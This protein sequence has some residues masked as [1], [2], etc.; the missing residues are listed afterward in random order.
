MCHNQL[1]LFCCCFCPCTLVVVVVDFR[2]L[3]LTFGQNRVIAKILL[4]LCLCGGWSSYTSLCNSCYCYCKKNGCYSI[5]VFSARIEFCSDQ[6]LFMWGGYFWVSFSEPTKSLSLKRNWSC[7][8]TLLFL[9][10]IVSMCSH[11]LDTWCF[12]IQD[13]L[14]HHLFLNNAQTCF[15]IF[16]NMSSSIVYNVLV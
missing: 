10:N 4:T 15:Q 5:V 14:K 1:K 7:L 11:A 6:Y 9:R 13:G 12:Q 16:W 3:L 8:Q 2:N